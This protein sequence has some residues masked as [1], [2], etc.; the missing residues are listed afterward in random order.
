MTT[1]WIQPLMLLLVS[2]LYWQFVSHVSGA[3]EPWDADGYWRIWYPG[4]LV[5]SALSGFMLRRRGWLGGMIVTFAQLPVMWV[6]AGTGGLLMAGATILCIL[7]VPAFAFSTI[8]GRLARSCA[9]GGKTDG[10]V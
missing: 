4:S 5:L 9:D 2:L 8:G 7:A 6:N 3:K 10:A 1:R